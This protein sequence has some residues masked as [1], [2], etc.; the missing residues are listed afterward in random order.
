MDQGAM[1]RSHCAAI[2]LPRVGDAEG[3]NGT[4]EFGEFLAGGV[5]D[6]IAV[7]ILYGAADRALE[8][9]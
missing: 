6:A 5:A 1:T 3:G 9:Y 8:A 2:A 4:G 7:G